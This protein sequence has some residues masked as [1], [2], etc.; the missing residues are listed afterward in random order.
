VAS[1]VT[2]IKGPV[3]PQGATGPGG[4]SFNY[5]GVYSATETY[6]KYDVVSSTAYSS[7][8]SLYYVT[9]ATPLIGV[10][11]TK[12]PPDTDPPYDTTNAGWELLTPRG[13]GWVMQN[14]DAP[15]GVFQD[16]KTNRPGDLWFNKNTG[17]FWVLSA[18]YK[19]ISLPSGNLKGPPGDSATDSG[20]VTPAYTNGWATHAGT[21]Q[22][23]Q[24]RKLGSQVHLRGVVAGGT[25]DSS[26]FTLPAGFTP[27]INQIISCVMT[28][29]TSGAASSGTAHT[30]GIGNVS[31]RLNI[32]SAG[33]VYS[34]GAATNTYV[35][36]DGVVFWID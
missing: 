23:A 14:S 30:H 27:V 17:D 25:V 35:S 33:L 11:P 24:Y 13:S 19:Y 12:N 31:G 22:P 1:L 21:V 32:T 28:A 29:L 4:Q 6:N 20:W 2:N 26:I 3:G 8:A 36:L 15:A 10:Q 34:Q 16:P 18:N 7:G 9:S 5:R